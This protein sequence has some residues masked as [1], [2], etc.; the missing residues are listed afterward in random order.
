MKGP[1]NF[2]VNECADV[3]RLNSPTLSFAPSSATYWKSSLQWKL[4]SK[5]ERRLEQRVCFSKGTR[6]F[7]FHPRLFSPLHYYSSLFPCGIIATYA[8]H[9]FYSR[10][11]A[12]QTSGGLPGYLFLIVSPQLPMGRHIEYRG[13]FPAPSVCFDNTATHFRS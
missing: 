3:L 4:K 6:L 9:E 7:A 13:L 8:V 12:N 5:L 10:R 11:W 2:M 1:L